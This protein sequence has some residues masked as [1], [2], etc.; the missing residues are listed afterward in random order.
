[1]SDEEFDAILARS[2]RRH[3]VSQQRPWSGRH[4]VDTE[5][6]GRIAY[7]SEPDGHAWEILT[8]SYARAP[9]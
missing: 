1:V 7:W 5:H 4:K 8:V 6:G 9:K 3:C 2:R